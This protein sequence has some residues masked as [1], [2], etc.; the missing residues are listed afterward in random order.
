MTM[1]QEEQK[2]DES[3]L[4]GRA[5]VGGSSRSPAGGGSVESDDVRV[6]EGEQGDGRLGSSTDNPPSPSRGRQEVRCYGEEVGCEGVRRVRG[7]GRSAAAAEP[8]IGPPAWG[9]GSGR[10][11]VKLRPQVVGREARAG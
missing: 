8:Q 3:A 7:G 10:K 4:F 6:L 9:V 11:M 2:Q 1:L 5:Q